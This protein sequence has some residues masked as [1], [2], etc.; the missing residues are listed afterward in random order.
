MHTDV[1]VSAASVTVWHRQD[2]Q[3]FMSWKSSDAPRVELGY[4]YEVALD[5]L[6]EE[7]PHINCFRLNNRVT[8]EAWELPVLHE[9][10]SLSVGDVVRVEA[11]GSFVYWTVEMIG[12][13]TISE[14]EF[15]QAT[16]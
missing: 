9:T 5:E 13:S 8:G 14:E 6:A 16:A 12:W 7:A 2:E 11:H 1:L 10:Q 4:T 3:R 15:V